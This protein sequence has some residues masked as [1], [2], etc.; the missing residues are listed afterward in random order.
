VL[1]LTSTSPSSTRALLLPPSPR[2]PPRPPAS[3]LASRP[4]RRHKRQCSHICSNELQGHL[5]TNAAIRTTNRGSCNQT[6]S[7]VFLNTTLSSLGCLSLCLYLLRRNISNSRICHM[8]KPVLH[9]FL[10]LIRP[11]STSSSGMTWLPNATNL[12]ASRSLDKSLQSNLQMAIYRQA[13]WL[14]RV[15]WSGKYVQ[16]LQHQGHDMHY[17]TIVTHCGT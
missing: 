4:A 8:R 17:S 5:S 16:A 6:K 7:T 1:S 10:I 13:A 14:S 3:R 11:T 2:S 12:R 15:R 9:M